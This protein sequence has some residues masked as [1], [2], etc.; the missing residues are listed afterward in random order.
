MR[1]ALA[2]V[3]P[4]PLPSP[5]GNIGVL[6]GGARLPDVSGLPL[7][8]AAARL[9]EAGVQPVTAEVPRPAALV[10]AG[11]V[12]RTSPPAGSPLVRGAT[13]QVEVTGDDV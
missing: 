1:G 12:L 10:P 8:E 13:V 6:P 3:P 2:A 7:A 9:R 5:D 11:S 4:T